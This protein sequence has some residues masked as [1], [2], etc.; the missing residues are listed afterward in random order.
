MDGYRL[1]P[2]HLDDAPRLQELLEACGD[3]YVMVEGRPPAPNAAIREMTE[4]PPGLGRE[5]ILCFG[6]LDNFENII[7]VIVALRHFR[8]ENQWYLALLMLSPAYRGRKLGGKFYAAFETL[9]TAQNASSLRLAVVEANT[10]AESFWISQGFILPR[11]YPTRRIGLRDHILIE[12]EK[13]LP[14]GPR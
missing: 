12:Y 9:I 14:P 7:G 10:R 13:P 3:Y 4:G 8:Q 2:L 1:A 11:C 5:N 6:L